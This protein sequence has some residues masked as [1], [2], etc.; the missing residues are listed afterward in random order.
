MRDAALLCNSQQAAELLYSY[1]HL[2]FSSCHSRGAS[3]IKV[4]AEKYCI[5]MLNCCMTQPAILLR[6]RLGTALQDMETIHTDI[7][8]CRA[9]IRLML[10][11]KR[12]SSFMSLLLSKQDLLQGDYMSGAFL[13]SEELTEL[14]GHRSTSTSRSMLWYC[15]MPGYN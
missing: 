14:S 9:W 11:Q 8:R 1:V 13:L 10:V 3:R 5:T 2:L 6:M 4:S 12:L 7:G 15:Q